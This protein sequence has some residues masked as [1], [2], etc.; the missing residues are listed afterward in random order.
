MKASLLNAMALIATEGRILPGPSAVRHLA[1]SETVRS[2]A[3]FVGFCPLYPTPWKN[4]PVA[5]RV[6]KV[7][8]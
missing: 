8:K 6:D 5:F 4:L 7:G 1:G 3:S 2:P